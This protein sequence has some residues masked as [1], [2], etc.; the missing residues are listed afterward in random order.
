MAE[1]YMLFK[2]PGI[3]S[4]NV[5]TLLETTTN[6]MMKRIPV[7]VAL[8]KIKPELYEDSPIIDESH[9]ITKLYTTKVARGT[10]YYVP[11]EK[12]YFV[13]IDI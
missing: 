13:I 4:H 6:L 5:D 12:N 2:D 10:V 3:D 8:A 9:S 1:Y 11:F 7:S